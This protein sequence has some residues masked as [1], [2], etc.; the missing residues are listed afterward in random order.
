MKKAVTAV[1]YAG[2]I[3]VENFNQAIWSAPAATTAATV[4]DRFSRVF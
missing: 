3:E 4:R 1:G 2:D